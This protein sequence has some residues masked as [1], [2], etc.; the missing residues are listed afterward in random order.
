[1]LRSSLFFW[2]GDGEYFTVVPPPAFTGVSI[3]LF[4]GGAPFAAFAMTFL[5]LCRL[6]IIT[7]YEIWE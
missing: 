5:I 6:V 2:I 7:S 3:S 4:V 1:L